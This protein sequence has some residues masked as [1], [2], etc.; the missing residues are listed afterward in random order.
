VGEGLRFGG[1]GVRGN[2]GGRRGR[3][4]GELLVQTVL[5]NA[6]A[7]CFK[8]YILCTQLIT[9][10]KCLCHSATMSKRVSRT[11]STTRVHAPERYPQ[12]T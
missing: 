2:V 5:L 10:M 8:Y 7:V 6:M 3:G 1:I 9:N 12:S 11:V 4:R